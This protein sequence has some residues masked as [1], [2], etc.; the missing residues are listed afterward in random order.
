MCI[1]DF[2]KMLSLKEKLSCRPTPPRQLD[3]FCEALELCNL[4]D[5]GFNGYSFIWNNRR[6][7]VA[8][9]KE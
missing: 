7:K 1:G 2:N 4:V 6:P 3:A 8:N 9:T 5:L